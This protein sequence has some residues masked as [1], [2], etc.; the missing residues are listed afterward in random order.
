MT[1]K[2]LSICQILELLRIIN[3]KKMRIKMIPRLKETFKK[4]IQQELKNKF[5]Y[6]NIYMVPEIKKLL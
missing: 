6:K 3:K 1:K 5:G 2:I 4:E